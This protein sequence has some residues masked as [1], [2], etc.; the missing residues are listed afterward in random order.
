MRPA[1][2]S[3]SS[4]SSTRSCRPSSTSRP[5]WPPT[6]PS[7]TT[8]HRAWARPS[9]TS[10]CDRRRANVCN[11]F[12][13]RKG[14]VDAG[15]AEAGARLRG[16]LHQ[17][18]GAARAARDAR[19]RGRRAR[20][21]GLRCG[22]RPRS[23]TSCG[24]SWPTSSRLPRPQVRV[25]VPTLGG[26]YGG[27]CYPKIE[28]LVAA[29]SLVTRT[30]GA[31]PPDPR[32]GVRHHH[33]AR[34]A[35]PAEDRP[36]DATATS[37]PARAPATSTPGPTRTSGRGSSRTAATAPA[38]RTTSPTCGSTRTPSTPTSCRPARSAAT[39]SRQAAWA[40]ETQMDMIAERLGMDPL[41]LRMRNLLVDGQTV[42]TG[43]PMVDAHFKELLGNA[44]AWIGWDAR[45]TAAAHRPRRSAPRASAAS[46]RARSPRRPR[47]PRPSSTRTARCRSS[48]ARSRWARASRRRWPSWPARSWRCRSTGSRSRCPTRTSRRTTS[49]PAPAARRTPW[50]GRSSARPSEIRA[51]LLKLASDDAGG[52]DRRPRT[53]RWPR[54]GRRAPRTRA[55]TT[56]RSSAGPGRATCWARRRCRTEGGLDPETGQGIGSVHWHQAAG[57][58]EVEVDL[59]TGKVDVAAVPRRRLL[60]AASS[61]RS[62]RSS[63][64]RATSRSAWARRSSRRC[65]STSG[66]L[67]NGNLGDYMIASMEDMPP[68]ST[69]TSGARRGARDPWHR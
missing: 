3:P 42:M 36:V 63:R 34:H 31:P 55:S 46:S 39:A 15:L 17:P 18:A 56:A 28:P 37:S 62:R 8:N 13:L 20:R 45:R 23:P 16:R 5:R 27:K 6:R 65:S 11:H 44:A 48:P 32:G 22:R 58:A 41:E 57:A 69:S 29:L 53:R 60:P 64:P 21:P 49:R 40:Y 10:S 51:Q 35:H 67:Q 38:A 12:K 26:G 33:Q 24:P 30:A 9:P 14:D 68:R 47:R 59:D 19:V 61:T 66:Q 2:R 1:R 54:P 50:A 7:C 52:G 25:I 4:R 43:E